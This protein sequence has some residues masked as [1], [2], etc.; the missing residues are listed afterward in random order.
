[1]WLHRLSWAFGGKFS[2]V[3]EERGVFVHAPQLV[4]M[5]SQFLVAFKLDLL[6]LSP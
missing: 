6:T 3:E 2:R 4:F 5:S 1:M